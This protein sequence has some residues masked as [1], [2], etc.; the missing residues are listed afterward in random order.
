MGGQA[1]CSTGTLAARVADDKLLADVPRCNVSRTSLSLHACP[2]FSA[3]SG[4]SS[5]TV[6]TCCSI[7][8]AACKTLHERHRKSSKIY[9]IRTDLHLLVVPIFPLSCTALTLR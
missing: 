5:T 6:Q 9:L 8:A 3:A 7:E 2:E 4:I 1:T